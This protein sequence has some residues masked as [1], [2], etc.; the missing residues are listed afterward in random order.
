MDV[1]F[2]TFASLVWG[3]PWIAGIAIGWI[4][5]RR[6]KSA[7]LSLALTAFA[8]LLA[9][10]TLRSIVIILLPRYLIDVGWSIGT[11][12]QTL[13]G[14]SLF[15]QLGRSGLVVLLAIAFFRLLQENHT[16]VPDL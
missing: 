12:T 4:A 2:T 1:L 16:A 6:R 3:A 9:L 10:Q 15:F 8:G 7:G 13:D 14:I 11:I 5:Y